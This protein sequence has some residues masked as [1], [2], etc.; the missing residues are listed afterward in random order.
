MK[1]PSAVNLAKQIH[2]QKT[3]SSKIKHDRK[4]T[5]KTRFEEDLPF[6]K[7]DFTTKI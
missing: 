4:N 3:P 2:K 7:T 1:I 5:I 6:P